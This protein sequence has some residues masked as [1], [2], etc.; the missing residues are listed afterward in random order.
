VF[1][2]EEATKTTDAAPATTEAVAETKAEEPIVAKEGE[3]TMAK[4]ETAG[5]CCLIIPFHAVFRIVRG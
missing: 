5:M 1:L 2:A 4:E 3:T